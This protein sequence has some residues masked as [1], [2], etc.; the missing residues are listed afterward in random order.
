MQRNYRKVKGTGMIHKIERLTSIGKFRDYIH[1]GDVAFGKLTLIYGDNGS[2]KTT[3]TSVF[4]SFAQNEPQLLHKRISTN[5]TLPQFAQ[6]KSRV[7]GADTCH[8]C[9]NE[10]WS[11]HFDKIEIF[12]TNFINEN[13]H[14]GFEF[15]EDH[16]RK[17][18]Q[19]VIGAQG[20]TLQ[21]EIETNKTQKTE[22]R[23]EING[24]EQQLIQATGNL[25]SLQSLNQFIAL[26]PEHA[27]GIDAKIAAAEQVLA[28][29]NSSAYIH[30]LPTLTQLT[31][32]S[33][34][35]E[36]DSLAQ[37]FAVT[38][39]QI[40]NEALKNLFSSHIADLT[41]H[42][43]TD[44]ESWVEKG[45]GYCATKVTHE[46]LNLNCPFCQHV[47]DVNTDILKAYTSHFNDAFTAFSARLQ[48][49]KTSIGQIAPDVALQRIAVTHETNLTH[50]GQWLGHLSQTTT[51]PA[52]D[53]APE[54]ESIRNLFA[55]LVAALEWKI[56]NP[57]SPQS[58]QSIEQLRT[59]VQALNVKII[60]YNQAVEAYNTAIATFRSALPS[61]TQAQTT[62][63]AH[64]LV[65]CR[66]LPEVAA[67]CAEHLEK[68]NILKALETLYT[69]ISRRQQ[70]AALAFFQNYHERINYYLRDIFH[71]PFLVE[72]LEHVPP[73]GRATQSKVGYKLTF[74]GHDISFDENQPHSVRD[75]LSDGDK[76]TIAVSFFLSK[77]DIDPDRA[78]KI[79]IFD[80]PLSSFDCNRRHKT[81]D[82]IKGLLNDVCQVVVLSHNEIFLHEISKSIA[83]G[84][85]KCLRI[86]Q[87]LAVNSSKLEPV[88]LEKLV[89]PDY[90]KNIRE[91]EAF[92]QRADIT[93]RERVLGLMRNV[94][95]SHIRF[96]FHRQTNHL[97]PQERTFGRL[98]TALDT[99]NVAF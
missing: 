35:I 76:S 68:S 44:A 7:V 80:D 18:H 10:G 71:T 2:G 86:I 61:V 97:P 87:N 14:S 12:D 95:E 96:K 6:L 47:L 67:L 98:I 8:T 85:K 83:L 25:L 37:D 99:A 81:V 32:F 34:N 27:S 64:K 20:V 15:T 1:A 77:A 65:N 58:T 17:L 38:T 45:A 30:Q 51:C 50:A 24:I 48:I 93:Q 5:A 56:S 55:D 49:H 90:F 40:Q 42:G 31:Q 59:T 89:E 26:T 16:K 19:F 70:T 53:I 69:D 46:E 21:T 62:L 88:D 60:A 39:I 9:R 63:N 28:N 43:M 3:L 11:N 29:A 41:E 54:S 91:L 33:L 94:L 72:E 73:R 4:R 92:L 79:F 66:F 23:Q 52:I 57:S 13:I 74:D 84:E 82:I 22:V 78:N 75:C 36:Y